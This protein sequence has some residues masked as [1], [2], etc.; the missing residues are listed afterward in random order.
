MKKADRQYML[1]ATGVYTAKWIPYGYRYDP[2]SPSMVVIDEEVADAI[3]YLFREYIAGTSLSE[4]T[5]E[6]E[7]QGYPSPARRREQLGLPNQTSR[8]PDKDHWSH[9]VLNQAVFNPIY[10]GDLIRS[11]RTWDAVYYY[12]GEPVPNGITLPLIEE[13]HH[14]ALISREDM[15]KA[16]RRYLREREQRQQKPSARKRQIRRE[17]STDSVSFPLGPVIHCGECGRLMNEIQINIGGQTC[18]AYICSGLSLLQPSKCTNRFYRQSELTAALLPA[19]EAERRQAV[20]ILQQISGE[21]KSQQ[22]SRVERHLLRQIDKAVDAVRKNMAETRRVEA[23]H[24]SGSLSDADYT[25]EA[26][27]LQEEDDAYSHQ[28]MEALVRIREFREV[29]TPENPWLSLY[30]TLPEN[31]TDDPNCLQAIVERIDVYPDRPPKFKLARAQEKE[32]LL[33]AIN[34]PLRSRKRTRSKKEHES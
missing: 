20:K 7:K 6:L 30:A 15:K 14:E 19:I 3:R 22:Y 16:S 11:G 28:V 1:P 29:C 25:V 2:D 10:A 33:A 12:S 21:E 8:D 4:I 5:Q 18:L 27:H 9:S 34:R 23:Q 24:K 17:L 26:Q 32:S 31:F 13:N